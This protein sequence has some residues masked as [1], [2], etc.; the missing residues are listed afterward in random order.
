MWPRHRH[1]RDG[2]GGE[3]VAAGDRDLSNPP[4]GWRVSVRDARVGMEA[5]EEI[6]GVRARPRS[7][8]QT[9]TSGCM[10]REGSSHTRAHRTM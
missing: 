9:V 5:E 4:A 2:V 1:L 8:L 3:K 10:G 7:L 6:S